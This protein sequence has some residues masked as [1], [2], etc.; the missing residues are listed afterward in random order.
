MG[1]GKRTKTKH[2][3]VTD[4]PRLELDEAATKFKVRPKSEFS[5]EELARIEQRLQARVTPNSHYRVRRQP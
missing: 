1:R 5:A 3:F 2:I 4:G